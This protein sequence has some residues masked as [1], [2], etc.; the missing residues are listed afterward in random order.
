MRSEWGVCDRSAG[1]SSP[2]AAPN[3]V[4]GELGSGS[5]ALDEAASVAQATRMRERSS[6]LT[7][8]ALCAGKSTP[9]V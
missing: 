3:Q 4:R 1:D 7:K 8:M 2:D 9:G 6:H 5:G